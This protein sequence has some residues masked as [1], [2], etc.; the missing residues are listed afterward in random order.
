MTQ[1][2]FAQRANTGYQV[3]ATKVV[4]DPEFTR[5]CKQ[6]SG[7]D[8]WVIKTV[9]HGLIQ[10]DQGLD[11]SGEGDTAPD[12]EKVQKKFSTGDLNDGMPNLR[13]LIKG[14]KTVYLSWS[15]AF[16]LGYALMRMAEVSHYG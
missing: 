9:N 13:L 5:L 8:D 15:E 12:V 4:W 16:S 1:N 3:T 7:R 2:I 10:V 6:V 11:P 14:N